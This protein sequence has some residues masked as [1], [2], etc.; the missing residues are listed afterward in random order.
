MMIDTPRVVARLALTKSITV[1]T[2]L[3]AC[4]LVVPACQTAG[5]VAATAVGSGGLAVFAQLLL[6]SCFRRKGAP[7]VLRESAGYV[8]HHIIALVFMV[9]ATTV[10]FAGWF[11]P[12]A[13][14]GTAAARIL[15]R[16]GSS[17]WLGAVLFGELLLWDFPC[18]IFIKKLQVLVT[19]CADQS[20]APA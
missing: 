6:W 15:V 10:G 2:P 20:D 17:L 8:A 9:L 13:A 5:E 4:L 12:A 18:S 14:T 7:I 3:P 19:L 16:D 11:S 1:R